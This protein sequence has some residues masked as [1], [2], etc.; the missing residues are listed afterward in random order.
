MNKIMSKEK[1]L[2]L[3]LKELR[4]RERKIEAQIEKL[5]KQC[6]HEI[7]VSN[8]KEQSSIPGLWSKPMTLCLLCSE[9]LAPRKYI[10]QELLKKM[11]K[12][13]VI[14]IEDYPNLSKKWGKNWYAEITKLYDQIDENLC[15][16]K[17]G[18]VLVDM[19]KNKEKE[20]KND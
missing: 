7:I 10:S 8:I 11:E 6:N 19:I 3:E 2:N 17:K 20:S 9:Y 18:E 5:Q 14:N 12:A 4:K 15:E 1:Q 16:Y 13:V